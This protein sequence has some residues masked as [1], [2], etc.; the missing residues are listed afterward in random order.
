MTR[1]IVRIAMWSGP[2]NISTAMMRAFGNRT[3]T[4]AIDEPFYAAYLSATGLDHP[5]RDEVIAAQ[6]LD[7]RIVAEAMTGPVE[8]GRAIFYQ[9]HMT[10]HMLPAFGRDWLGG[11]TSAF[12]IRRPESVLASYAEKRAEVTLRDIGFVEQAEIFDQVADRLGQ[13]PPV[14]DAA[15]VLTDPRGTLTSLCA[16][17]GI[18][19]DES[20]LAWEPGR[21]PYD[22]VWAPVWYRAV[23]ASSGF[24]A[25]RPETLFDDLDDRLKPIAE[26]ALAYYERLRK[27]RL[28]A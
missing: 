10:H 2:R 9:K 18:G 22:G 13:A 26:E 4:V 24:G 6:P 12:L 3:D 16:A 5:M 23:E 11:V 27:F 14:I 8:D 1:T 15:D 21:K 19:F 7:W 17:L 25:P 20:M 28:S